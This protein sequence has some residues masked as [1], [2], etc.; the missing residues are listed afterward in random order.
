MFRTQ[1]LFDENEGIKG[2]SGLNV[3]S[4]SS[5]R[6]TPLIRRKVFNDI[7]SGGFNSKTAVGIQMFSFSN[8]SVELKK[9]NELYCLEHLPLSTDL[10]LPKN[11]KLMD[12]V[13][14]FYE[15]TTIL[16]NVSHD[17]LTKIKIRG[18]GQ[19]I[20]GLDEHLLCDM[21]F[22]SL[23]LVFLGDIDGWVVS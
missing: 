13:V 21:P 17:R 22:M 4:L 2:F 14:L 10:L 3:F 23:R 5:K 15:Q 7:T 18:N 11:P 19:R 8:G 12:W 9:T 6:V 20:M 1:F 16:D